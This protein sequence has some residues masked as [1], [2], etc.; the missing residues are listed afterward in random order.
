[1]SAS[2]GFGFWIVSVNSEVAP[3][4]IGLALNTFAMLGGCNAVSVAIAEPVVPVFVPPSVDDTK[5]LTLV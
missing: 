3:T 4:R 2:P 1:M 5:P